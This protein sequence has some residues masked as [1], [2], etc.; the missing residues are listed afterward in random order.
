[1]SAYCTNERWSSTS[2]CNITFQDMTDI[3]SAVL[4]MGNDAPE[5]N[6]VFKGLY[7]VSVKQHFFCGYR[8]LFGHYLYII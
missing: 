3:L 1:M 6:I 7:G 2:L 4:S 5:S 8:F